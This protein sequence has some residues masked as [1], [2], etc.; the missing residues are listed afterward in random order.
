MRSLHKY[1]VHKYH[2]THRPLLSISNGTDIS[3]VNRQGRHECIK[4]INTSN[5]VL[6]YRQKHMVATP[7]GMHT[8]ICTHK[9]PSVINLYHKQFRTDN[10]Q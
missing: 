7:H 5:V 4:R 3:K 6:P 10:S 1:H 2:V 8:H 9:L